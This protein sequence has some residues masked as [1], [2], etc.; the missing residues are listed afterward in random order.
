MY[1]GLPGQYV[2]FRSPEKVIEEIAGVRA[3]YPLPSLRFYD[4]VFVLDKNWLRRFLTM[5]RAEIGVP[6]YCNVRANLVDEETVALLKN[7]GCFRTSFGVESGS[8]RIRNG[9]LKK[10][11][12]D[13]QI[14]RTAALL[15]KYRL[16]FDTTNMLGLPGETLAE[17][18]Q[19]IQMNIDIK[20]GAAWTS[21]FQPY[22][23]TE[24]AD[25]VVRRNLVPALDTDGE[26]A[27]AHSS[28]PLRQP[29]IREIVNLHKFAHLVT[30]FPFLKPLVRA[31]IRWPPNA[32]FTAVYKVSYFF[33]FYQKVRRLSGKRLVAEIRVAL[34]Y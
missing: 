7:A 27:D 33:L 32:L 5:Y 18:W 17:A 14:Y 16:E 25:E 22:P 15:R 30:R 28:S 8:E 6:F 21:V 31:L 11:V 13:E 19:T 2:R 20:A 12:T 26:F 24:L 23:R 9:T 10:G 1:R 4:D 29:D 3:R 34:R